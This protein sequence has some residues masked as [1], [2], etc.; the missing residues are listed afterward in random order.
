MLHPMIR[1]RVPCSIS[2]CF[3]RV[4]C[5]FFFSGSR[6]LKLLR[7][8]PPPQRQRFRYREKICPRATNLP[9]SATST[10]R[11][12]PSRRRPTSRSLNSSVSCAALPARRFLSIVNTVQTAPVSWSPLTASQKQLECR[13]RHLRNVFLRVPLSLAFLDGILRQQIPRE[14]RRGAL[15]SRLEEVKP[16]SRR[17]AAD[18]WD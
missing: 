7:K 3:L 2:A 16:G 18:Y 13:T 12:V 11:L 15:L 9:V 1:S 4:S 14:L 10:F 5:F 17:L 8:L 6:L